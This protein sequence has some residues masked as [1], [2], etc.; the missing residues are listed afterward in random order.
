M[1]RTVSDRR[2]RREH[3]ASRRPCSVTA[4]CRSQPTPTPTCSPS[5][6]PP[7]PRRRRLAAT[8][9][10]RARWYAPSPSV[11][12]KQVTVLSR[13]HC[14]TP[15]EATKEAM[16]RPKCASRWPSTSRPAH[17]SG[18]GPYS[19]RA[20]TG[21]QLTSGSASSSSRRQGASGTCRRRSRR[22]SRSLISARKSGESAGPLCGTAAGS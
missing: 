2:V 4:P 14:R 19:L 9:S 17:R 8:L 18:N 11:H 10:R 1:R 13:G 7:P 16:R 15:S 20:E 21:R 5:S 3:E 22:S 12:V 6:K